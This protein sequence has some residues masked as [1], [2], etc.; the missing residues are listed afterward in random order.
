M[1]QSSHPVRL[2]RPVR[3][4]RWLA[5]LL[6]LLLAG[7]GAA[8][9][10]AN[11]QVTTDAPAGRQT[12]KSK[13]I[14]IGED[15]Q[16]KVI[17][18]TGTLAKRGY[19]GVELS[20]LTPELRAHFGAPESAGVMVA[21]VVAGSPAEKAGLRIGDILT[22]LDGKPVESSWDVR[23]RVRPLADGA[24]LPLSVWRDGKS[25]ELTAT[26]AQ[27]ER[28]EIDLSPFLMKGADAERIMTFRRLPGPAA[29]GDALD[30]A[31]APKMRVQPRTPREEMLEKK[32]KALEKRL[33]QLE[34]RLPKP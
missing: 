10:P 27:K 12:D 24:V 6:A 33:N 29:E 31:V 2:I 16:E 5:A 30:G 1:R 11:A 22:S 13:L 14:C 9:L 34:S 3:P 23:A 25:L 28:R 26:V 4:L 20:E 7:V 17:E 8:S 15:G 18:G 21:R 19:L 32:L